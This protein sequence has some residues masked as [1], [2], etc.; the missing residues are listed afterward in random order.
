[1]N[2]I[3]KQEV[4][5]AAAKGVIEALEMSLKHH[6]QGRDAEKLELLIAI[7]KDDFSTGD[8]HCACCQ[9]YGGPC[10]SQN[11]CP[12]FTGTESYGS[13]CCGGR[14]SSAAVCL[15]EF[16]TDHSNANFKAFQEAEGKVCDYIEGVLEKES[17]KSCKCSKPKLRHGD[18][19]YDNGVDMAPFICIDNDVFW[20]RNNRL[21]SR[22]SN[23]TR[24]RFI[25]DENLTTIT[26]NL[27]DDLKRNSEDLERFEVTGQYDDNKGKTFQ[28]H[29]GNQNRHI[30]FHIN[31]GSGFFE[32][33]EA[34]EFHQKLGQVINTEKRRGAKDGK[35]IQS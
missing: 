19:G 12:L 22:K 8:G 18:Y 28:V 1:M 27:T 4:K 15:D 5:E 16:A 23:Y 10:K 30:W 7:G 26:G 35:K 34:I 33:D 20:L 11:H 21:V 14:W 9:K 31:T 29:G 25:F 3:T 2:W 32:I 17:K 24:D 6:Q 13:Q